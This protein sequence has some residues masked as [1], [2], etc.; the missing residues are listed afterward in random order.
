MQMFF[1][2]MIKNN[3]QIAPIKV[4]DTYCIKLHCLSQK[5][6]KQK[7]NKQKYPLHKI[8]SQHKLTTLPGLSVT[9]YSSLALIYRLEI[10]CVKTCPIFT[11]SQPVFFSYKKKQIFHTIFLFTD[12]RGSKKIPFKLKHN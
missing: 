4:N 9:T 12:E 2:N 3:T 6:K 1:F 7:K 5:K 8:M 10:L 11:K